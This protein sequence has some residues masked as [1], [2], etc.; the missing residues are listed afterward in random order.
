I[1]VDNGSTDLSATVARAAGARV[2]DQPNRGYGNAYLK[3]FSVAKGRIVIM[4]DADNSYDFTA[5]PAL[6]EPISQGYEYVLGSRFSGRIEDDAMT[7]SHRWIGNPALTKLL[8][9]L[10]G[11]RVSDAHSGFRAITKTALDRLGLEC[12]GMEFASEMVV[13]AARSNLRTQEVPIIYYPRIGR[14]KLNTFR[15]GWRHLRYLIR[16]WRQA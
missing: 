1:V 15:D 4:G 6:V 10:F 13:K 8:N 7:W 14:S 5:I 11:L 3:G 12:E 2:V 9:V 16:Q